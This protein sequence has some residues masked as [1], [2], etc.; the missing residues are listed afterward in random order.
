MGIV[1][2]FLFTS[3]LAFGFSGL[4]V[5][6]LENLLLCTGSLETYFEQI[7]L[8]YEGIFS[9]FGR[10]YPFVFNGTHLDLTLSD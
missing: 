1:R 4:L 9:R 5:K 10:T 3:G 8:L 7:Q 2:P 6:I